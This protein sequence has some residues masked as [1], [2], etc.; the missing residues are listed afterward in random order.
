MLYYDGYTG[1][2]GS[3]IVTNIRLNELKELLLL[4]IK[5]L[6]FSFNVQFLLQKYGI[7]MGFPLG[8]VIAGIFMIEL[9]RGL[10]PEISS[11]KTSWKPYEDETIAYIKLEALD[12][13]LS[14]LNSFH[15]K[16]SFTYE[17]EINGKSSFLDILILKNGNSF[18]TTV[19][20]KSIDNNIYLH[21]ESFAPNT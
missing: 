18:G 15:E 7:A 14:V 6:H 4:C 12:H 8:L 1:K 3:K 13:V 9:G 11:Y 10:F 19:H 5:I 16:I 17:K 20:R 21:W 2:T